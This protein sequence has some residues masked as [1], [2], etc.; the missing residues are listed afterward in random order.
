MIPLNRKGDKIS[1]G[2]PIVKAL[3]NDASVGILSTF[4]NDKNWAAQRIFMENI[5]HFWH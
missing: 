3:A 4:S 2:W 1:M 5:V